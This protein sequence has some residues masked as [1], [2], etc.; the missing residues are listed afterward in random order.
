MAEKRKGLKAEIEATAN[1]QSLVAADAEIA[2][3]RGENSIIR[4]R[5]KAALDEIETAKA[6]A[7]TIESLK[8]IKSRRA[9]PRLPGVSASPL[10]AI[11]V[12][13][14][15]HVEE[16]IDGAT[17]ATPSGKKAN[18]YTLEIAEKRVHE[19]TRRALALLD[20]ESQFAKV[21]RVIVGAIGD[22][23]TGDLHSDV[24]TQ[25]NPLAATRYA[26]ELLTGVI[27]A[28]ADRYKDVLVA[29][30]VGN[31]GRTTK[32]PTTNVGLNYEQNLYITLAAQNRRKN[33]TWQVGA[34][35]HNWVDVDG[36][37]VRFHHG[38]AIKSNGAI[39]GISIS[40]N[41]SIAQWNRME[42]AGLDIF[43]HHHQFGWSYGRYV[44][45]GSLCGWN[46]FANLIK[47]E[48]QPP[49]QTLVLIDSRRGVTKAIPIF[50]E[51]VPE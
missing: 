50:C 22:F 8:G 6:Q 32:K 31:H 17:V 21:G 25:L 14:D 16:Y 40:A 47:A 43:G 42:T 49:V 39:G 27:D 28:V 7:R 44:S 12:C 26:G 24:P 15:W 34:G 18:H 33:V 20:H 45:N 38:D 46:A 13:S 11:L 30:C 37:P 48:W 23:I 19:M 36:F 3:L 51:E 5:Y 35:Y 4:A 41:K 1:L 9:P 29:T 2:R 10:T